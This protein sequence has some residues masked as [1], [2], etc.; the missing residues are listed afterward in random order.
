MRI[1]APLMVLGCLLAA[2]VI[3][4]APAAGQVAAEP[5]ATEREIWVDLG[6]EALSALDLDDPERARAAVA[7]MEEIDPHH[8]VAHYLQARIAELSGDFEVALQHYGSI[9]TSPDVGRQSRWSRLCAGSWVRARGAHTQARVRAALERPQALPKKGRCLILP[10]EP[11]FLG[12]T[13]EPDA[14]RLRALGVAI[15]ASVID[16][17]AVLPG[18]EPVDLPVAHLL[19]RALAGSVQFPQ[20]SPQG[21]EREG[22]SLPP[23]TTILGVAARLAALRPSGPPPGGEGGPTPARYLT[24]PPGGEWTEELASALAHFQLE[25]GLPATG[26]ADP[27]TRTA[28]ERATR[29]ERGAVARPALPADVTD[30]ARAMARLL[31]AEAMLSGTLEADGAGDLRWQLAWV[32][33]A[34]GSLLGKAESG[35]LPRARFQEAFGRMVRLVLAG[36]PYSPPA[37]RIE[38]LELAAPPSLAGA[39]AYGQ[40]LLLVEE[41][42]AQD[43]A[44]AFNAAARQGAGEQAAWLAMAWSVTDDELRSLARA[45][46]D[47][48]I[49]GPVALAPG[50]LAREGGHLAAGLGRATLGAPVAGG[51]RPGITFFPEMGWIR[52]RGSVEG[53]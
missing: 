39:A 19:R 28:L 31:G 37:G 2:G 17:L 32:S 15:A 16:A 53:P 46:L 42:R 10:L 18:A 1:P 33:A 35:M 26:I 43:A 9:L 3:L 5:L 38:G 45:L 29:R 34:D 8:P 47:E 44:Y 49:H 40:A 24:R 27:E 21:A 51:W 36:S 4:P 25:H 23:V 7:A 6:E 14:E 52:V 30:P 13:E 12:E 20:A 41:G 50:L 11:I 22:G 48:G